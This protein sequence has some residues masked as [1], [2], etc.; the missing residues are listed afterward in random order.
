MA[1]GAIHVQ[2][3]WNCEVMVAKISY[4]SSGVD[5]GASGTKVLK[6]STIF[7]MWQQWVV[8]DDL[9]VET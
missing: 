7:W 2:Y 1:V 3:C 5:E 4:R 8:R 9:V 6:I